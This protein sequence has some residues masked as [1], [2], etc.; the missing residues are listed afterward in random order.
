MW[1]FS[2][3]R[4]SNLLLF[5]QPPPSSISMDSFM[6]KNANMTAIRE[7]INLELQNLD[8]G[9]LISAYFVVFTSC[10]FAL[11][12][13]R[14]ERS[15]FCC[16]T[17]L[18]CEITAYSTSQVL[19]GLP[20]LDFTKLEEHL[21]NAARE[22]EEQDRKLLGEEVLWA[23]LQCLILLFLLFCIIYFL[24]TCWDLNGGYKKPL[25]ALTTL[26]L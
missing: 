3:F 7:S 24:L 13:E 14:V 11:F 23:L 6:L 2:V 9:A 18:L 17:S 15:R 22:R 10:A 8:T 4:Y 16:T 26:T 1:S 5:R 12:L 20:N 21:T 19:L 25:F